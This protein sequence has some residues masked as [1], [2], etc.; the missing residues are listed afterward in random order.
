[1]IFGNNISYAEES[2]DVNPEQNLQ[3]IKNLTLPLLKTSSMTECVDLLTPL[4]DA[5]TLVFL[6]FLDKNFK[7]KSSTSSLLNIAAARYIQYKRTLRSYFVLITPNDPGMDS[8]ETTSE[9]YAFSKCNQLTETYISQVKEMMIVHI[10]NN[11]YQ[12]KTTILLDKF[13]SINDKLSELNLKLAQMYGYFMSFKDRL[14]GF[15]SEC[16]TN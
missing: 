3:Q 11:V 10:R 8:A 6:D 1:M 12:K 4:Y 14:P 7:N 16:V 13:K 2:F 9:L 5:E 15:L